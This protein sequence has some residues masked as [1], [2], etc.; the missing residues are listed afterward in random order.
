MKCR[1]IFNSPK[2]AKIQNHDAININKYTPSRYVPLIEIC[3]SHEQHGEA[4]DNQPCL[5]W[6][7]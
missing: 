5:K 2:L 7:G 3:T 4:V 6:S 1:Q